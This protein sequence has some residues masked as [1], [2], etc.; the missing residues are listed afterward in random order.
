M[1]IAD[2]APQP[3]WQWFSDIC[4]IPHPSK[5]EAELIAF[6]LNKAREKGLHAEQDEIGNIRLVK[7]ATAGCES[8]VPV[9]MQ[10][11]IDMVPQKNAA[12]SHDFSIDAIKAYVD[13]D[14]VTAEGTTLGADNGIGMAAILAVM[15]SDDLV[16]GPL[17]ALLTVDEE[18]GMGGAFE[19]RQNWFDAEVLLNL[20]TEEEGELYVGCAGGVDI[21]VQWPVAWQSIAA[22]DTES[23]VAF[24]LAVTGLKGGHSGIDIDKGRANANKLLCRIL[25]DLTSQLD[26][27]VASLQGGTLRNAIPREAK[28]LL[29]L[30]TNQ[31]D[32][33]N[34]RLSSLMEHIQ[35]EY[36]LVESDLCVSLTGQTL[37]EAVMPAEAL[38]GLLSAV[39]ACPNGV[40][41]MS[42]AFDG[43]VETS[44]SLG[45]IETTTDG[46]QVQ[47]MTRSLKNPA[48][49]F[50]AQ[51]IKACF[52]LVGAE[53][54][55]ENAYPGWS[56]IDD[57][58]LL[59]LMQKVH[60]ATFA[61]E[62]GVQVIHAGLECGLLGDKY[63]DWQMISFGPTITGAHSPDERV[64]IPSTARF[65]QYLVA[66]LSE[67]SQ[68]PAGSFKVL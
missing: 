63:P 32:E 25:L 56:P 16:H 68:Q 54:C 42:N 24:E 47:F 5:Q 66:S 58:L 15:F 37:P 41:R 40:L 3:L 34:V 10:S 8:A 22:Q 23:P 38:T 29:V 14:W 67:L 11:H 65:W 27:E 39:V 43:V 4:A 33:L 53:V 9:V 62:A 19:L 17:E 46:I 64:S 35:D 57:S 2:L 52:E 59:R 18:A 45:V 13:G 1:S 36:D 7:P 60:K 61:R 44:S 6:I 30:N 21:N 51:R 31:V 20:D 55:I 26:L 48:R 50:A 49:D 28:A 12:T